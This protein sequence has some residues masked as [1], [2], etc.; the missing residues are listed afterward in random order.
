[1]SQ[2][3][4]Q[5]IAAMILTPGVMFAVLGLFWLVRKAKDLALG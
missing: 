3:L 1:M 5:Y 4:I 2:E